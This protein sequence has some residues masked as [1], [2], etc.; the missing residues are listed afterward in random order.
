MCYSREVAVVLLLSRTVH[1]QG[2]NTCSPP[3]TDNRSRITVHKHLIREHTG[4]VKVSP[5]NTIYNVLCYSYMAML[6]YWYNIMLQLV[7]FC[8]TKHCNGIFHVCVI[9]QISITIQLGILTS[10]VFLFVA[11]LD[12]LY[13]MQRVI[14][15]LKYSK[16]TSTIS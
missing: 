6:I 4:T 9:L 1:A 15:M 12:F 3:F 13:D 16:C 10:I 5:S 14:N 11:F 8:W 7:L 2:T